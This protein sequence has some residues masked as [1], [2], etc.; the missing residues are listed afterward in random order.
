MDSGDNEEELLRSVTLQN[1]RAVHLARER[2]ERELISA[3]EELERKTLE[4]AEQREFFRITLSSIGDGVIA[5][6][7]EGRISFLNP[8]AEGMTG[9]KSSEAIGQPL[10]QVFK[11]IHEESREPA[12]NPVSKVLREG[13]VVG[14]ANHTVLIARDGTE[15]PIADSAAPIRDAAGRLF[16]VVMVFQDVTEQRRAETALR[17]SNHLLSESRHH[18]EK[19]VQERTAELNGANKNLRDLSARLLHIRDHE[20]RRLARELHDSVGQMLSAI[21]MNLATVKP[22]VHKLDASGAKAV[23]ENA[24]LI[25]QISAEIRTMSYLLHPPLLDELGLRSALGWYV[26]GFSERSKIKVDLEIPSEF[27]RLSSDLETPIFRIVQE[28][29]TNIHRHSGSKAALIRILREDDQIVVVA[30][31]WGKGIP[32]DKLRLNSEGLTGVGFRGMTERIRYLGGSLK[33]HSDSQGTVVTARL[34]LEQ[35]DAVAGTE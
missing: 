35:A 34:P 3:K 20:S 32:A 2:A 29:L 14:L 8:V 16:G 23:A 12:P 21:N 30:Q 27:G 13:I 33:L 26:D 9:W 28:C 1:A 18:L 15:T 10:E 17:E 31:D 7:T 19:R 22:Q 24:N 5:T 25:E 4:L 6:D 11:I